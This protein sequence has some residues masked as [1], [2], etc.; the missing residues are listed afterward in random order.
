[1]KGQFDEPRIGEASPPFLL[2]EGFHR[3]V[4]VGPEM[5]LPF[6][7]PGRDME[8]ACR[9][10]RARV[11]DPRLEP[12]QPPPPEMKG[13]AEEM[14]PPEKS[15]DGENVLRGEGTGMV[16]HYVGEFPIFLAP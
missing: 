15:P 13:H 5:M 9:P 8:A 4:V 7:R 3:P 14:T 6:L 2:T 16:K 12:L 10:S 1:M 11:E